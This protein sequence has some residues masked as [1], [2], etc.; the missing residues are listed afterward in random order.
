MAL[1]FGVLGTGYWAQEAHATALAAA[2]QADLVAIWGR[3]P[4]RTRAA[5]DRFGFGLDQIL[6]EQFPAGTV[7]M[8]AG[9]K[10]VTRDGAGS[11]QGLLRPRVFLL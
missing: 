3:D 2:D 7:L 1:R 8:A 4:A 9:G 11:G 10:P 6:R 5:A